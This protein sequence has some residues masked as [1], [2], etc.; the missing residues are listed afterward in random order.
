MTLGDEISPEAVTAIEETIGIDA[1]AEPGWFRF[2][3]ADQ[4]WEWSDELAAMYGY[5]PGTVEP[6]TDL[7][8]SHK[9]PDDRE[10]VAS[11]IAAAAETGQPF[12]GR[13][14]IIDTEGEVREVVVVGDLLVDADGAVTGT[15][16]YYVDVS[17]RLEEQRQEVLEEILPEMIESRA[18]IEQ[19][20][21]ALILAYGVNAEQAFRVLRWRSQETNTK[22]RDLAAQ[23]VHELRTI[24]K[25]TAGF[26]TRFDHLLLTVHERVDAS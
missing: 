26:R 3:F 11:C 21:G 10:H 14:R 2:W 20:K 7:L 24:S 13:H 19:A 4:R 6:T 25:E 15:A 18:L 9:H 5:A 8:L 22:L 1:C 23:F 12:C 17:E 16:G